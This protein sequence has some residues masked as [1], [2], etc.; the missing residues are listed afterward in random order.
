MAGEF[1]GGFAQGDTA[2]LP[3]GS[4]AAYSGHPAEEGETAGMAFIPGG[5][6]VMGS[7]RH[8]PEERFTHDTGTSVDD[9]PR[10]GERWPESNRRKL[11]G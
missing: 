4:C 2:Q 6:F 8:Q 11:G 9:N 7:E 1:A 5:T 3:L 10:S